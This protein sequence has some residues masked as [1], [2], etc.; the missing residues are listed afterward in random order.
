MRQ[1]ISAF[2]FCYEDH[3][4]LEERFVSRLITGFCIYEN[5]S[6][7]AN[8]LGNFLCSVVFALRVYKISLKRTLPLEIEL[9]ALES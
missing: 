7:G 1:A 4:G 3:E 9:L 6:N 5:I 2:F 8:H